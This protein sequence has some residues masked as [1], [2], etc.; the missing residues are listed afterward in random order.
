[1]R[2]AWTGLGCSVNGAAETPGSSSHTAGP[3]YLSF[4][5]RGHPGS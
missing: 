2:A 4:G 1:M 3:S 5:K